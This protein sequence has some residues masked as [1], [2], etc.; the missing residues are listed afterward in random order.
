MER[1]EIHPYR[2]LGGKPGG[3][4]PVRRPRRRWV[5]NNKIDFRETG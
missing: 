4:K 1:R 2:I 3:N 5:D